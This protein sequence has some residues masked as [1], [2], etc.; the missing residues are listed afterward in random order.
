MV[1]RLKIAIDKARAQRGGLHA[2]A[3]GSPQG[4]A[5]S[6]EVAPPPPP[7]PPQPEPAPES[8]PN[9]GLRT[10]PLTRT[11]PE[12]K[13]VRRPPRTPRRIGADADRLWSELEPLELDSKHLTD[14]RI[15]TFDK[16][17][18]TYIAFDVLRTRIMRVFQKHGWTRLGITSPTKG[19]GKTFVAANLGLSMARS[20]VHRTILMDM[21][22]RLPSMARTLGVRRP[23]KIRW[24]LDGGVP[25][26][27][28]LRLVG[29][30]LA[31]GLN[32]ERVRDSAEVILDPTTSE[33]LE[34]MQV[35]MKPDIMIY[36][37]PPVLSCD[38][39]IGF[40]PQLDSVLLVVSGDQS[41]PEDV[42]ECERLL[43]ETNILGV[44]LNKAE[45]VESIKYGYE[46]A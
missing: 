23:E 46:Y 1:E 29:E 13:A 39:V 9:M 8:R 11:V 17:D 4:A 20:A 25:P 12:P 15:I 18:P 45:D 42:T 5:G 31:I 7:P 24:F 2:T 40:L 30:N 36:D 27:K 3:P 33:V 21:D 14:N 10:T 26:E 16:T 35:S 19:C 41:K 22:L 34:D 28:Y 32:R 37:L 6:P 44:L 43:A 38:D